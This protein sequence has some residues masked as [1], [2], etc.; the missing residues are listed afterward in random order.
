MVFILRRSRLNYRLRLFSILHRSLISRIFNILHRFRARNDIL[1]RSHLKDRCRM[2]SILRR[3][4]QPSQNRLS[5]FTMFAMTMV[6][7]RYSMFQITDVEF[8]FSS[9][10][11]P[12]TTSRTNL[13]IDNQS[14]MYIQVSEF[15]Q[16]SFFISIKISGN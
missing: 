14:Q 3:S 6:V 12:I 7:N 9:S 8:C 16:K 15:D 10:K 4:T 2:L 11:Q 5:F 1:R 13:Q